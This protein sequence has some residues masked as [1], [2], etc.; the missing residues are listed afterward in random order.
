MAQSYSSSTS[1][2]GPRCPTHTSKAKSISS[3]PQPQHRSLHRLTPSVSIPMTNSIAGP[4]TGTLSRS[5]SLRSK[6]TS[7]NRAGSFRAK[8]TSPSR[9]PATDS[10]SYFPPFEVMGSDCGSDGEESESPRR[11][12]KKERRREPGHD[13]SKGRSLGSIAGM[14]SASLSWGLSSLS[15]TSPPPATHANQQ[16]A[17][18]DSSTSPSSV[19]ARS[20]MPSNSNSLDGDAVEALSKRFTLGTRRVLEPFTMN[21]DGVDMQVDKARETDGKAEQSG[22]KPGLHKRRMRSEFQVEEMITG[23]IMGSANMSM[24][25]RRKERAEVNEDDDEGIVE[26][27]VDDTPS[28]PTRLQRRLRPTLQVPILSFPTWRFP[29]PSPP[30]TCLS[31]DIPLD[32]FKTAIENPCSSTSTTTSPRRQSPRDSA[33]PETHNANGG[34]NGA[35]DVEETSK[36]E[37]DEIDDNLSPSPTSTS[38]SSCSSSYGSDTDSEPCTPSKDRDNSSLGVLRHSPPLSSDKKEHFLHISSDGRIAVDNDREEK[39]MER[40]KLTRTNS[41][42]SNLSCETVKQK[43]VGEGE[44]TPKA[45]RVW[46]MERVA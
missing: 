39:D 13:H 14:M 3:L 12:S 45:D 9:L 40:L 35:D 20:G 28:R 10:V 24:G 16:P 2:D 6:T 18:H 8:T 34:Q 36:G 43:W 29:L 44:V 31:P 5:S 38:T 33:E 32:A 22:M 25:R 37:L 27:L 23:S 46:R 26:G 4:S 42:F 21:T 7:P 41:A 15:C 19:P 17:S 11:S 30:V 1:H